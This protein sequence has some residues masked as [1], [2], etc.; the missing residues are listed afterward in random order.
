M[1]LQNLFGAG[2][3]IPVVPQNG[4]DFVGTFAADFCDGAQQN[5]ETDREDAFFAAGKNAAAK[6]ERC[7]SRFLQRCTTEIVGD[8]ADFFILFGSGRNRFAKLAEAEHGRNQYR[9]EKME[10][11]WAVR[12]A[13]NGGLE[14]IQSSTARE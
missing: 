10:L 14:T 3:Q 11:A 5:R 9:T 7:G 2:A 12:F 1:I 13:E 8:Q 4:G 6:K